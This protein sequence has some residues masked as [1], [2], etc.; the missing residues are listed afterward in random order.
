MTDRISAVL[1]THPTC[2]GCGE[3]IRQM[4]AF[5]DQHDVLD[6]E[7]QSLAG[8]S[9]MILAKKWNVQ[10]VPTIVFNNDPIVRIVGIPSMELIESKVQE[11]SDVTE[12]GDGTF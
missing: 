6:F 5:A 2:I 4:K 11:L 10:S 1:F 3:A 8:K 7:V 12:P 9:G